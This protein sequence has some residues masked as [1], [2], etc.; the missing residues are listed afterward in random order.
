MKRCLKRT[1]TAFVA[2]ATWLAA[3]SSAFADV[4]VTIHDGLISIVAKNATVRQIL[5]EWARVGRITVVNIERISGGPTSIELTNVSEEHALDVVLRSVSGYLASP[6]ATAPPANLSRFERVVVMP[7][8]AAPRA[9]ASGPAAPFERPTFQQ[10]PPVQQTTAPDDEEE[11]PVNAGGVP[12]T[13]RAPVFN[14]FPQPQTLPQPV[15]GAGVQPQVGA[16]IYTPFGA[17]PGFNG[18]N[19]SQPGQTTYQNPSASPSSP[20]G[21]VAVPGMIVPSPQPQ[22]GQ[23]GQ[24]LAPGQVV[25]PQ[26]PRRPGGGTN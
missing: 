23:P 5:T 19:G 22:P 25:N 12:P 3:A 4:Q 11:R 7:A 2:T 8:S 9:A 15:G 14:P 16:P 13:P 10:P 18:A 6:R 17:Q 21:G 24:I 26:Q 1:I 20:V